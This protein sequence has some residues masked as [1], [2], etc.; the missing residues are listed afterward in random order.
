MSAAQDRVVR[1]GR[2][3]ALGIWAGFLVYAYATGRLEIIHPAYRWLSLLA[4]ALLAAMC[5]ACLVERGDDAHDHH[6]HGSHDE[7]HAPPSWS[8]LCFQV[9]V[10]VP[11][12]LGFFAGRGGLSMQAIAKRGVRVLAMPEAPQSPQPPPPTESEAPSMVTQ[13]RPRDPGEAAATPATDGVP[14]ATTPTPE[15]QETD[16]PV[17]P[18]LMLSDIYELMMFGS[19]EELSKRSVHVQGQYLKD[20]TCEEGEFLI[21]RLAITCCLAD[22]EPIAVRVRPSRAYKPTATE[23]PDA[24]IGVTWVN[25]PGGMHAAQFFRE[26]GSWIEVKGTLRLGEDARGRNAIIVEKASVEE[27][28]PPKELFLFLE[29]M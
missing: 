13:P 28:K 16:A 27:I 15:T 29:G 10:L 26:L 5:A 11:V 18:P 7:C 3:L 4:A 1:T 19:S 23:T 8:E 12:A 6:E 17:G 25:Q 20:D 2:V 14:Q 22:A 9:V 24:E 21:M